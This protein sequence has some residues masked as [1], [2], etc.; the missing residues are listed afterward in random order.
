MKMKRLTYI[1][2]TALFVQTAAAAVTYNKT[3]LTSG[4]TSIQVTCS[5]DA[6][7]NYVITIEGTGLTGIGGTYCSTSEGNVELRTKQVVSADNT[8]ITCTLTSTTAPKLYTPLYVLTPGEVS[9]S[10]MTNQDIDYGECSSTPTPSPSEPTTTIDWSKYSYIGD[11][12]GG[13]TYSNKYKVE[14]VTGLSVVNIQ[15]PGFASEAGIYVT[16]PGEI[17]SVSVASAVQ[18]GGTVLYLSA[19]TAKETEVTIVY[20]GGSLTFHVYYE[21]GVDNP[22][23]TPAFDPTENLAL[24]KPCVA[25]YSENSTDRAAS[26][27]ND[28]NLDNNRWSSNGAPKDYTKDWWYVDLGA[29]YHLSEIDIFWEAAYSSQFVLQGCKTLPDNVEDELGWFTLYTFNGTPTVGNAEG[30]INRYMVDDNAR[31]VRIKSSANSFDNTYGMSIY[32][33]RVYGTGYATE[34]AIKPVV[35]KAEFVS[36]DD[37]TGI[38]KLRLTASKTLRDGTVQPVYRFQVTNATTSEVINVKTT[39]TSDTVTLGTLLPC[40]DYNVNVVAIDS[41]YNMSDTKALSFTT[42]SGNMAYKA[43]ASAGFSEGDNT[44]AK[45]VDGDPTTRWSSYG[46]T[47][48]TAWWQVDLGGIRDINSVHI[49]FQNNWVEGFWIESSIDGNSWSALLHSTTPP[50]ID[51]MNV[52]ETNSI[53]RYVRIRPVEGDGTRHNWSVYEFEV[54]GDCTYDDK[55]RMLF[56]EIEALGTTTADIR[57]SAVDAETP[58][59][60]ITYYCILTEGSNVY[61]FDIT[62]TDGVIHLQDMPAGYPHTLQVWAKDGDGNMSDNSSIL[63]FTTLGNLTNLYLS[64]SMNGWDPAD[65]NYQFRSTNVKDIYSLTHHFTAGSYVYK[66]TTGSFNEATTDD[67]YVNILED[68]DVTFYARSVTNFASSADS[69]YLIGEAVAAGWTTPTDAQYCEWNGIQASWVGDVNSSGE[70]KII[71]MYNKGLYA[72]WDDITSTNQANPS[73]SSRGIFTFDL[74]TLSWTWT[75]LDASACTFNGSSG[76]GQTGNGSA[77][78]T[79]G[80]TLNLSLNGTKDT[81]YLTAEFL[82]TD[83]TATAAYL[84]NY[85]QL[86]ETLEINEFSLIRIG[87][88]QVFEGRVPIVGLTNRADGIMRFGIKFAFDGGL[89]VTTPEY[90]YLDGNGCAERK[91]VIYHHGQT[92]SG[93]TDAI[94]QYAGGRV[95]QPIHYKRRL[96]PGVWETLCLPFTVDSITVYDPDDDKDYKLY[97]Q[98]NNNGTTVEGSFWLRVFTEQEVSAADFQDNWHDISATTMTEA[99]PKKGVPY[100]IRVPDGAYYTDKYLVFHGAGYQTIDATYS[101]TVST[102]K[103]ADKFSYSGNN[104]MKSW[105]L[106]SAYVLDDVGEY[107]VSG[108]TV[109]LYPFECAVNAELS[110][111][112]R[113]PRLRL[114][115]QSETATGEQAVPTTKIEAGTVYT[116]SGMNMGAFRSQEE[117]DAL[118]NRLAVGL[119]IVRG[120]SSAY[121]VFVYR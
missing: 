76:D 93:E 70:Y 103:D 38:V 102:P 96:T 31:Y 87:T 33:F 121:K 74:P 29:F 78:F 118:L 111:T 6:D 34:D 69:L 26:C 83:K 39:A 63:T 13:G 20:N 41:C 106:R 109:T 86:N 66:L 27:A 119:Y 59:A 50:A 72:Y 97:A 99:L 120:E 110:T 8:T 113:M 4:T 24:N 16:V 36:R 98:Y 107:F 32:E 54:T 30:N 1:L 85:P 61:K 75:R 2:L 46:A 28:G 47:A 55:P 25:G 43:T 112:Q 84:Q 62:A 80:Y 37:E 95:L 44:A 60:D 49:L 23:P 94:E 35:D 9:F 22:T 53:G 105:T 56:A 11:G 65:A 18:S 88:T 42:P 40:T 116:I 57:V 108:S 81:I 64:G 89:R 7:C 77:T 52:F 3:T 73:I 19:F 100:I 21:D 67:H 10:D 101:T 12:A 58:F 117:K 5:R 92:P 14:T 79:T 90:Y 45:A 71:K 68:T 115:K 15:Q 91:F 17:S 82:D 114:N 104:T 51:V 48:G